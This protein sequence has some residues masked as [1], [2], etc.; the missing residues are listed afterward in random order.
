MKRLENKVAIITGG[1]GGLGAAEAVLFAG[2]GAKV[3]IT[4]IKEDG[5]RDV[6][7]QITA[8]GGTVHYMKH[9]V[10]SEQD[11]N[12]VVKKAIEL[13]GSI[14]ILVNNAGIT[15]N[16]LNSLEE[17]SLDE[18]KKVVDINLI[19]QFIGIKAVV[20]HMKK[21]KG[22]SIINISS[23][24]GLV[25]SAKAT[26]YTA[27]KGAV[28]SFTKGA[29]AEFAGDNIRVN[30]VH[31]GYVDTPMTK[32]LQNSEEF[33]KMAIGITP[34]GREAVP[35]EVAYGVL[36]LASDESSYTTGSEM[37]IDGGNTAV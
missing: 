36:Y 22:G 2:E 21:N 16:I 3:L 29:A 33:K 15:G 37:V 6:S 35:E 32:G 23:I 13:Y 14:H 7:N 17:T 24:A 28:R 9:D 27:S 10:T 19:S 4:D 20:P 5:L 31:P 12:E 1:A 11:W 30:S 26:A 34:L 18:F 25:G 8:S